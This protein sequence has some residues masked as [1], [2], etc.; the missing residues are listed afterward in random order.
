V[1]TLTFLDGLPPSLLR[2]AEQVCRRFEAVWKAGGRP[3]I[4]DHLRE[5]PEPERRALLRELIE[6]EVEYRQRAGEAPEAEDYRQ[7]F[8]DVDAAWLAGVLVPPAGGPAPGA[9]VG[10]YELLEEIGR[11]GMGV[12]FKA[13]Q[14][15]LGRLVAVKMIL[16]GQ[17][18]APAEVRRFQLEAENTAQLDHPHIVPILE[19][20]EHDGRPFFSTK[21]IEGGDLAKHRKEIGRDPRRAAG[22]LAAVAEAVHYA[23]QR[24]I[25]HRDLKPAN[26]LLDADGQPH[27]TDFGLAKRVAGP[28]QEAGR[29][30]LTE[31]G[32]IVGTPGYL[33]P[34]QV[35]G[36]S[37]R[38][39]TAADIYA[40]G[41][42][43]YDLLTGRAPFQADTPLEA[44]LQVETAEPVPPSR[45]RPGVPRDLETICLRCLQKEP[46]R[47]YA[48]AAELAEDLRR[49]LAGEPIRARP[50]RAW[51]RVVKWARRRPAAAALVG[52]SGLASLVLVAGL[53]VGLVVISEKQ[54]QTEGALQ[55]EKDAREELDQTLYLN[56]TASAEH[57]IAVRNW[58]RAQE[59]LEQ[60]PEKLRGWEWY[61]LRRLR[62]TPPIEPLPVG[63]RIGMSGGAFDLAFHPDGRLLAIPSG[64]NRIQVWDASSGRKVLT[65]A[66]HTGRVLSVAFS[67]PDG[68][69]L[70][71]TSEDG[72]VKVWDLTAGPA[73]G[74]LREA[75]FTRR[76]DERVIGVAFSP[77][78]RRFASASGETSKRGKVKV[79]DA[80]SGE[81]RFC[82]PG[83]AVPNAVVHLAFSPDGRRLASGSVD[84]T[85][86]VW[87]LTT[88]KEV[89]TLRGHTEPILNVLFTPDGRRL[90]SAGRDRVVYVWDLG[91]ADRND[92]VP[93]WKLSEFSTSP[94]C[95]ALSPDGTRLAV[96]GPTADGNVRVYDLATG[97]VLHTLM[98]DV[99]VIS[100]AFSSPDGRRLASAGHDRI[101]R[102]WDT[103]TGQEVLNL[104]GHLDQVG[105]V[106]FS[107]DGQRLASASADGTVRVWDASPF[108]P[109]GAPGTRTLG[110]DD[111][112]FFGVAFSP[113]GRLLASASADRSVKLWDV[114]TGQAVTFPGHTGA[115]LCV[116][117]SPDGR[118][119]LSGSM[120]RTVRLW[121]VQTGKVL[122]NLADFELMVRSVAFSPDG[123]AFAT[124][125]HQR[126]QLWDA[127][128]GQQRFSQPVDPEFVSWVSFS[129]DGKYV[130]AV[131]HTGTA[132]VWD[133]HSRKEVSA[134]GGHKTSVFCVAFHPTGEYLASGDTD[135]EVKL[136]KPSTPTGQLVGT[137][138]G[139]TDYIQGVVF[140]PDGKYLA[141]A[142]WREVIVWDA[143][144]SRHFQKLRQ[145][146][147]LAGKIYAVAFSPDGKRLAAASGYKGKG[148][149]KV[150]DAALWE[151]QP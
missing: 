103:T 9:C 42:V 145:F 90:I 89:H 82:F 142:S 120:D 8:P 110:G 28:G 147:R 57:E 65:V 46:G 1:D 115:V 12:V 129:R 47:R 2:H 87:D 111:G 73:G 20:G 149:I 62:L 32:A 101:I 85:V 122:L 63:E 144:D 14:R 123:D 39:T 29:G 35:R 66:G 17:F 33:A 135:F 41:A 30:T 79:W 112:E 31:S 81:M 5:A 113:D 26:I 43:L 93:R 143:K 134:F 23:H 151:K 70:A 102:L 19:V 106:L 127:R 78:G 150:W 91:E 68:R 96:G 11:G 18:A 105:R 84:N 80:A 108:D 6:V 36:E 98:G 7:R 16:A 139:H 140:S 25:L 67:P 10:D 146:D 118:R 133:V 92:L 53:A 55:R 40:L 95:I 131:G 136:W 50:I 59:F 99:R 77:D 128:T 117:F 116:A 141:T 138:A 64:G 74:E 107:P 121:D 69:R 58:A 56:G 54:R 15:R 34:E 45:L 88:G 60:C 76:H 75:V 27:L 44:L 13:R 21:L 4:E 72:E 38:L 52:V 49:H 104:R 97:R 130:A 132:R 37:K 125:A 126:L 51:E 22:L 61:Y 124:G 48:S 100:L 137:L 83:Q 71:S 114:Q 86:K 109:N 3:A 94:W 24:G 119:L 148:E